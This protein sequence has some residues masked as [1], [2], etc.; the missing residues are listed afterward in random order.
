[1][2]LNDAGQAEQAWPQPSHPYHQRLVASTQPKTMR[3]TS[4]G[5]IELVA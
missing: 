2:R 4:Q 3:R 5:Y 1:V